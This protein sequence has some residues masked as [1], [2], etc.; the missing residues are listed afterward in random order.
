MGFKIEKN[1]LNSFE[2][3]K[4]KSE[5]WMQTEYDDNV[6]DDWHLPNG[7]YIVKFKTDDG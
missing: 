2:F 6:L 4:C 5:H 1:L 3:Q 7:I